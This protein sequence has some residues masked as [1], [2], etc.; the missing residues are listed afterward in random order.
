MAISQPYNSVPGNHE[1]DS[2]PSVSAGY[3]RYKRRGRLA[4]RSYEMASEYVQAASYRR[5][6]LSP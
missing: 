1:C 2:H 4:I 6:V 3:E 5:P